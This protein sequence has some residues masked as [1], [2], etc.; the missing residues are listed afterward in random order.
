[1]PYITIVNH[2]IIISIHMNTLVI[3]IVSNVF[4][5]ELATMGLS[6][7]SAT[8]NDLNLVSFANVSF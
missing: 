3:G 4:S 6:F 7:L 8:I 1:M 5:W 2:V